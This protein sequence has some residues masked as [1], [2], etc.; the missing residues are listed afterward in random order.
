[1][2]IDYSALKILPGD[3]AQA[4]ANK[5]WIADGLLRLRK[6]FRQHLNKLPKHMNRLPDS[7]KVLRLATWNLR[8]FGDENKYGVRLDDAYYFIAEII[9]EFDLVAIQEVTSDLSGLHK[10]LALL[11]SAWKAI[12]T[13]VSGNSER[14]VFIYNRNTCW[15][16]GIAG[17]LTLGDSHVIYHPE[18]LQ[19]IATGNDY[20]ITFPQATCMPLQNPKLRVR[21]GQYQL[22][23][24]LRLPLPPGTKVTL[25]AGSE[26]LIPTGTPV[27]CNQQPD[28]W[29]LQ[30]KPVNEISLAK[31]WALELPDGARASG[32]LQFARTP[33]L[34][35]FQAGWLKIMLC[36]VHIYYGDNSAHGLERRR[37]EIAQLT[38]M[39]AKKAKSESDSEA[40]SFF[41]ALGDF[42]IKGKN[43][44]TY[45]ALVSNGFE[46]PEQ[47][48]K[49]PAG[50]NVSRDEYY[51]Q[52]A[53]YTG[54][55]DHQ[56]ITK[57]E[58]VRA[59]VFDFF[60]YVY[61]N[62]GD[63]GGQDEKHYIPLMN[64]ELQRRRKAGRSK[65]SN[66]KYKDWRT[67]QMSDHLP[68][69]IELKIDYSDDYLTSIK[70]KT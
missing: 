27:I 61:R 11:G 51:D 62:C 54:D 42:N 39:L 36:T 40:D 69:W 68:M 6:G 31:N 35:A 19:L 16:R 10:L 1:M 24:A 17:E 33:Y 8:E 55:S 30:N 23:Q 15:F 52:I 47:I 41:F 48:R 12:A 13:D 50:T 43:H 58:T 46:I 7:S 34:V 59:G 18:G 32:L 37:R 20:T 63:D 28:T 57:V 49:I 4:A 65:A 22:K 21:C 60:K 56:Q 9:S 14:M 5:R 53:I 25:P 26:L 44:K 67:F 45:E 70:S 64:K 66:W 38:K 2:S 29:Q 3:S